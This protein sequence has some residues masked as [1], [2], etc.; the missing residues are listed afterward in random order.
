MNK[1]HDDWGTP[2]G[3]D[4][5]ADPTPPR[6]KKK[7]SLKS[8]VNEFHSH[9]LL[10]GP[11]MSLNSQVNGPAMTKAFRKIIDTG[12]SYDDI[13]KMMEQFARD[14]KVRPVTDGTPLWRVFLGRLDTLAVKVKDSETSYDYSGPKIDPRLM[15]DNDD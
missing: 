12:K 10:A 2:I 5:P 6:S 1:F 3:A 14:I 11:V 9:I 4:A 13:R 15:K 8:L 7:D